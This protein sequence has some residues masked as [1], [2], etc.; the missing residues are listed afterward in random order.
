MIIE[1][2]TSIRRLQYRL[3]VFHDFITDQVQAIIISL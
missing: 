2:Y 3:N 1:N